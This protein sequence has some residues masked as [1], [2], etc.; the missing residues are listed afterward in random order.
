[1]QTKTLF[2]IQRPCGGGMRYNADGS[3]NP[4][5]LT[6]PNA[7]AKDLDMS[8]DQEHYF[9][10]DHIWKSSTS[11]KEDLI[12][13]FPIEDIQNLIK[14]GFNIYQLESN[15]YIVEDTQIL[16]TE[17]GLI[18]KVRIENVKEFFNEHK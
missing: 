12:S 5:I 1:M 2:R 8:L 7:K 17:S 18:S 9:K 10:G 16:Y 3:F 11:T 6:I 13:W 4:I 15:Q 14:I